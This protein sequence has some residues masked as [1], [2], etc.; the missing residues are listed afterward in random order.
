V[1]FDYIESIVGIDQ[2][3]AYATE[4]MMPGTTDELMVR[5]HQ[6]LE[7]CGML[8]TDTPTTLNSGAQIADYFVEGLMFRLLVMESEFVVSGIISNRV[9]PIIKAL[10]FFGHVSVDKMP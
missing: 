10:L 6:R 5:M 1:G 3:E 7:I 2:K 4:L 9:C 8:R